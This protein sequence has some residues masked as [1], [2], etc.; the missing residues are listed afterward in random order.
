[1]NFPF[2]AEVPAT[3]KLARRIVAAPE[4]LLHAVALGR[5]SLSI[6]PGEGDA[7]VEVFGKAVD[8]GRL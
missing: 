6:R 1:L 8:D 3:A 5:T 2:A 7:L 4:R